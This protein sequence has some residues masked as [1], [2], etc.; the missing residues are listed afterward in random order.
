MAE[1]QDSVD[2]TPTTYP[3]VIRSLQDKKE[4]IY[5]ELRGKRNQYIDYTGNE[6]FFLFTING[7]NFSIT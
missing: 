6:E 7:N 3:T 2:E 4:R 1:V 5:F